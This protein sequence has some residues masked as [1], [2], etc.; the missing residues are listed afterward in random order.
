MHLMGELSLEMYSGSQTKGI[1]PNT[2]RKRLVIRRALAGGRS[3]AL[4]PQGAE[5]YEHPLAR[6]HK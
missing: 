5:G 2:S 3:T 4:L 1:E 6:T